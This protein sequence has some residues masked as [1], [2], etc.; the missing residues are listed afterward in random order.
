MRFI[1]DHLLTE[2]F[3]PKQPRQWKGCQT[4]RQPTRREVVNRQRRALRA[5]LLGPVGAAATLAG[6]II[7]A[8]AIMFTVSFTPGV[9]LSAHPRT[10]TPDPCPSVCIDKGHDRQYCYTPQ[11]CR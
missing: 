10:P 11:E 4:P 6:V 5:A 9:T 2:L 3:G 8:Y 1:V 7:I